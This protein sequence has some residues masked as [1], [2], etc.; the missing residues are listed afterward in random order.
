MTSSK[1]IAP[2]IPLDVKAV[3][4]DGTF[5]GYAA[6]FGNA[7]QGR[8]V[9]SVG[10]FTKS[11]AARPARMVRMLRDHDPNRPIGVWTK[12][13]EDGF[14]LKA[15]GRLILETNLGRETHALLKAGAIDGLSIGYRP[16]K[17]R[18]DAAKRLRYLEEIDLREISITTF[19]MNETAVVSAVKQAD[20]DHA[21]S[22]GDAINRAATAL[23]KQG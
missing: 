19:P 20:R 14:G 23:R 6:T 13:E 15:S 4:D 17:R 5:E 1:Q 18:Y 8:D 2:L 7:D 12:L 10:A 3:A 21:H 16:V 9:V 22:M 11:L